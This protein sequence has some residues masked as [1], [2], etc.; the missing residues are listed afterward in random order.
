MAVRVRGPGHS[1]AERPG[2]V[3]HEDDWRTSGHKT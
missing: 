1:F 2:V 3:A